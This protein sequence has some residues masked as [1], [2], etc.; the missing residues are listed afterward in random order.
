MILF[1]TRRDKDLKLHNVF[2][3]LKGF[4]NLFIPKESDALF[5]QL[6]P[7]KVTTILITQT[8]FFPYLIHTSDYKGWEGLPWP[9]CG[10]IAFLYVVGPFKTFQNKVI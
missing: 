7:L 9:V 5:K 1:E 2:N 3:S 10:G 8:D 4:Y 6:L